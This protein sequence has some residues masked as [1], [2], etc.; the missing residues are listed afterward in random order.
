MYK[1]LK[2][3][4]RLKTCY[5]CDKMGWYKARCRIAESPKDYEAGGI[6]V[7]V[8]NKCVKEY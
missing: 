7:P 1:F 6:L 2:K 3:L 4:L 8:C 5:W